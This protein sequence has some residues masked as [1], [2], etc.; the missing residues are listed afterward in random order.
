MAIL[1][2]PKISPQQRFDLEDWEALLASLRTDS[3]LYTKQFKSSENLIQKGFSV[4]GIGLKD[5]LV[6]MA[7]ASLIIPEGAFDFSYFIS[8]PAEPDITVPDSDLTDSARN[9]LEIQLCTVDGVPLTK[10]FWDPDANGGAGQEF[11][12]V[13]NTITDLGVKIITSTGG[14]S[15]SVDTLPLA[16]IDVDGSGNIT[17]IFDRRELFSRL[18]RPN[19]LDKEYT[20]GTKLEPTYSLA[21]SGASGALLAGEQITIGGET[22]TVVV[23]G[24]VSITMNEPTGINFFPGDTVT[25]AIS[26]E[27]A[28][29]D[30]ILES[31]TGVDKSISDDKELFDAL[32]TEI[33]LMKK[34]RFWWQDANMSMNGISAFMDSI[35]VQNVVDAQYAWDGTNFSFTDGSGTPVDA[36][37]LANLR[38]FGITGD[39]QLTRQDGTGGSATIP[40]G[41]GEVLFIKVPDTGSRVY[42][43]VGAADT[44]FQTVAIGSYVSSDENYWIAYREQGLLYI[45]GYGEMESGES[46]PISD[47][48]KETILSLISASAA[49]NNQDRTSKLIEGGTWSLANN[50]DDLTL[51]ANAYIE[52]GGLF[53]VRNTIVA[54]TINLPNADSVAYVSINRSGTIADNLTV[55][56]ADVNTLTLTDDMVIIARKV[57]TGVLVGMACFLL[58]PDTYLELDGAEAEINRLLGQL[59]LKPHETAA[60]KARIDASD[61]TLLNGSVLTQIVGDFI[62][63]FSGAVINFTTGTIL[64][65]DDSTPLGTNFTPQSIT[66]SNYF[67]YGISLNPGA[68][69]ADNTQLATV[70]VD[71]ASAENAAAANAPKPVI[72]GEIKLGAI[73]VFNNSGSIEIFETRKLG[74]GSGA[75]GAG[76]G[77]DLSIGYEK[78]LDFSPFNYVATNIFETDKDAYVDGSSTGSYS[79]AKKGFSLPTIGNILVDTQGFNAPYLA[80]ENTP[81][82]VELYLKWLSVGIDTGATYEVSRNGGNEWQTVTMERVGDTPAFRG[83]HNFAE[84]ASQQTILSQTGTDGSLNLTDTGSQQEL[85]QSQVIVNTTLIRELDLDMTKTGLPSGNIVV[86]IVRDD[87][88]LP[89]TDVSDIMVESDSIAVSS[90]STGTNTIP[91]GDTVLIPGTYHI[92]VRTDA[93]Y[94]SSFVAATTEMLLDTNSGGSGAGQYNGTIWASVARSVTG[95]LKGIELDLRVRVTSSI[96]DVFIESYGIYFDKTPGIVVNPTV[97]PVDRFRFSGDENKTQFPLVNISNPNPDLLRMYDPKKGKVYVANEGVFQINGQTVTVEPDFFNFPG[98]II[99]VVFDQVESSTYDLSDSNANNIATLQSDVVSLEHNRKNYAQNSEFRFFQRQTPVTLTSVNDADY[100]PDRFKVMTSGTA[101]QVART[102]DGPT[103]SPTRYA[104]QLRQEEATARQMGLVQFLEA[105]RIWELRGKTVTFAVWVRSD[106]SEITQIKGNVVEWTG[107]ADSVTSDIVSAWASTPT[108]VANA[109]Y[110]SVSEIDEVIDSTWKQISITVSIGAS[111]TNLALFLWT[112]NAEAQNNDLHVS[113]VQLVSGSS[114][115][116]WRGISLSQG[117]DLEECQRFYGK[118]YDLDTNPGTVALIAPGMTNASTAFQMWQEFKQRMRASASVTFYSPDTGAAGNLRDLNGGVDV[119]VTGANSETGSKMTA[120]IAGAGRN[121]RWHYIAESEL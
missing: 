29:V 90:L 92:I 54:Q 79:P 71:L 9:Y 97:L 46:T 41:E 4:S 23:G 116:P 85:S 86:S 36:D 47:P 87:T 70:Q 115:L 91:L 106:A 49:V 50:G 26:G 76:A 62:L 19:D 59:K 34:T 80:S 99:D 96:V 38:R 44:N 24:T 27:T 105:D 40:V 119:S 93:A 95:A 53:K 108:L 22:A 103:S 69:N 11:N 78:R 100:G 10:A 77:A 1:S 25:G 60:D 3:K 94:K 52:V 72:T 117:D 63:D 45:R 118:S 31:F 15:G 82:S 8:A 104:C 73:Q 58:K 14:F 30:T 20:W 101:A 68:I 57:S 42:S 121:L 74:V 81:S 55:T 16:I 32:M 12:Q 114:V 64:K 33:K 88:G 28:T 37:V 7:D 67:W 110:A 51:S 13:V 109:D 43:G 5:A 75:G 83:F 102:E 21:L 18:A 98:E 35:L 120:T 61:V 65:E 66:V 112:P 2:R 84:E 17:S 39:L 6:Q 107:T 111:A 89:S 56:V 48:D 113:Q